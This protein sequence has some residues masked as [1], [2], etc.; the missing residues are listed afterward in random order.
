[1]RCLGILLF[2]V[3]MLAGCNKND[4]NP[5]VIAPGTES[6]YDLSFEMDEKG[7]FTVDAKINI[8][9][10]SNESWEELV[11][12]FIPNIFTRE[13]NTRALKPAELTI[14]NVTINDEKVDYNLEQD[15]FTIPLNEEMTPNEKAEVQVSYKFELPL[16]GTRFTR[17][18]S[19][20]YLA[21]W[22][23]MVPTYQ[24]G[25]NKEP[26]EH[27]GESYHTTFSDFQLEYKVPEGYTVVTSADEEKFPSK[28]KNR[29]NIDNVKE[30][31]VAIL[32]KPTM[33]KKTVDDVEIRVFGMEAGTQVDTNM[34]ELAAGALKY[35][36]ETLGPYPHK[37]FDIV[38]DSGLGM[39]YPGI[40]TTYFLREIEFLEETVVHELGHQW[41]YGMVTNDPFDHAWVDE[42]LTVLA[43]ELYLAEYYEEPIEIYDYSDVEVSQLNL[44]LDQY[45][46]RPTN[47]SYSKYVYGVAP[48]LIWEVFEKHG[49]RKTAEDFLKSYVHHYKYK[50]L[51]SKEFI[52]FLKYYLKVDH[53]PI[54]KGW[55]K[56]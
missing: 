10:I 47:H 50:E 26:Y 43:T 56:K 53:L 35:F 7:R 55:I 49:G 51:D 18:D 36:E 14:D 32:D 25:W 20:Y 24:N 44:P 2:V 19:N 54:L 22:Y 45:V 46:I 6:D 34:M 15:R 27:F 31:F 23:P 11:F 33:V 41:F 42:S 29:Y 28:E 9:N 1:M 4:F 3:I 16:R 48:Q 21:Q 38:L 13:S 52:R 8:K 12:Y 17:I 5:E 37:Q 40:V 30:V 39:E